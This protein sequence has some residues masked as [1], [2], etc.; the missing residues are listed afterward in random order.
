MN[1]YYEILGLKPGASEEEIKKAWKKMALQWHPDRNPSEEAKVKIQEVNEA[2]EILMGK[3]QAPREEIPNHGFRNP[4]DQFRNRGGFKM[5]ARPLN[6]T[7]DLTVEEVFNGTVKKV[8]YNVNRTCGTCN[9]AGGTK[10]TCTT[11]SG[12]GF[13]QEN[14]FAMGMNVF[15]MCNNCGGAG[16]VFSETCKT[17]NSNGIVTQTESVDLTVTRGVTDGSKM[18]YTNSGN[19]IPGANRGDIFFTIN[20][21]EHP[22][23][24][25]EG[26]NIHKDEEISFIDMVLG[27]EIEVDTLD[28]R[29]KFTI[30]P[31]CET[32]TIFRLTKKGVTDDE[33]GVSGDLYVKIVPKVPKEITP[34]ETQILETLRSS[35]NFS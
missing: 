25:L 15:S 7:V 14:N 20:V 10:K 26:L 23:Y 6:L 11:C 29:V 34:E 27:K 35:T 12:R 3:K 2:Y 24:T 32:N 22:I 1:K 16:Q 33:I 13:K 19:D 28:G 31:G 8:I 30:K 21:L 17:C 18:V 9:G 4:F 5:K